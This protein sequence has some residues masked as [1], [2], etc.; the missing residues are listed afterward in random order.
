MGPA[1]FF[2]TSGSAAT[3][4]KPSASMTSGFSQPSMTASARSFVSSVTESPQPKRA[5][6]AQSKYPFSFSA[7]STERTPSSVSG[8][9]VW[10]HSGS[11]PPTRPTTSFT[12]ATR[13]SPTPQRSAASD[14]RSTAPVIS[15]QP[16]KFRSFP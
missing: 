6:V 7:A 14:E 15:R 4:F 12:E 13:K 3:Q 8:R 1:R 11:R 16:P 5:A 9:T 10:M 2:S